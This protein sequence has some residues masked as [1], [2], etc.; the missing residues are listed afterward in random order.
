MHGE[1]AAVQSA[2]VPRQETRVA[3]DNRPVILIAQRS[4]AFGDAIVH[5]PAYRAIRCAFPSHRVVSVYRG[6]TVFSTIFAS[7][8]PLF[9]DE[10]LEFQG[11][12]R[13]TYV[14]NTARSLGNVDVII[15]FYST[16]QALVNYITSAGS[17][18]R[19]VANVVGLALRRGVSWG[20]EPRP[21]RNSYRY[22]RLVEVLAGRTLPFDAHL[23]VLP[24]AD[25][26]IGA[27]LP[28]GERYL[29]IVPGRPGSAKY[30]PLDRHIALADRVRRM[31][32]RPVYMLGPFAEETAQR[33]ALRQA[34]PDAIFIDVDTAGGDTDYLPWLFQAASSRLT[35]CVGVDGGICHMVA[36]S[37]IPV[38]TLTGP[39]GARYW[40]P[41]TRQSWNVDARY[42]GSRRMSAIPVDAVAD[43]V[44]EMLI[45]SERREHEGHNRR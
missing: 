42:F 25:A 21:L 10:I 11:K 24:R 45:W 12:D 26:Q 5:I 32:V 17:A 13:R 3:A 16:L 20:I 14:G 34:S 43:V 33:E 9:M 28:R 37:D 35:A 40:I 8:R 4:E 22:H 44:M 23:P 27:L 36:T 41:V 7:L 38:A 39:I 30:W 19:Y 2:I 1:A 15:D 18:P 29:G 31:G 6:G